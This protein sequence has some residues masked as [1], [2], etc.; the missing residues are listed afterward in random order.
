MV[1]DRAKDR[2]LL[3]PDFLELFPTLRG[4]A[5]SSRIVGMF[6]ILVIAGFMAFAAGIAYLISRG[7]KMKREM[8]QRYRP[9]KK[10]K[11]LGPRGMGE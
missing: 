6:K 1:A 4:R 2:I 9:P 7:Q 11:I 3:T 8:G 5:P 10:S